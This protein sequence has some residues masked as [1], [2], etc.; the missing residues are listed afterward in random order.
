MSWTALGTNSRVPP[1]SR[2]FKAS[3]LE[4]SKLLHSAGCRSEN[5]SPTRDCSG[6][7]RR[8]S[9]SGKEKTKW[10][11]ALVPAPRDP[12][13]NVLNHETAYILGHG[14]AGRLVPAP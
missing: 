13:H 10:H 11:W 7:G 14:P 8:V 5:A 6:D 4:C 9:H 12:C 3:S 1:L 2:N